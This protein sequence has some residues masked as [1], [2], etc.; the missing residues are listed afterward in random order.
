MRCGFELKSNRAASPPTSKRSFHL[1]AVRAL[2]PAAYAA[3]LIPITAIRSIS[4][5]RPSYV[6][7]ALLWLFIRSI[8]WWV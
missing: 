6:V 8:S 7:L 2:M 1:R 4:N 3:R 5:L